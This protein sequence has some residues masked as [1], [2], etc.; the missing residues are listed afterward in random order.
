MIRQNLALQVR[1]RLRHALVLAQMLGPGFHHE[2][3]DNL[4]R[5]GRI[6]GDAPA[7]G[8]IAATF[9]REFVDCTKE[10]R[11]VMFFHLVLDEDQDWATVMGD[12]FCDQ[13]FWPMV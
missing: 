4:L 8:A 5:I 2:P 6:L 13:R 3:F 1:I 10:G 12:R 7:V 11:A 9:L